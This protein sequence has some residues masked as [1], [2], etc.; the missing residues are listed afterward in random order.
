VHFINIGVKFNKLDI[1]NRHIVIT[2]IPLVSPIIQITY[3]PLLL[4]T[5]LQRSFVFENNTSIVD[6]TAA[7]VITVIR[8][9]C[10]SDP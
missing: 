2:I 8:V 5:Y 4:M 3:T 6:V 10:L 7:S 9:V 1:A